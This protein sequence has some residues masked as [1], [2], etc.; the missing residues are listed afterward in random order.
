MQNERQYAG[1]DDFATYYMDMDRNGVTVLIT[2]D[3]GYLRYKHDRPTLRTMLADPI[4]SE[5][6]HQI[7]AWE[8]FVNNEAE[9]HAGS[10]SNAEQ[11]IE[12]DFGLP[13]NSM[14]ETSLW[15]QREPGDRPARPIERSRN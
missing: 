1:M 6:A 10:I 2:Y 8:Q 4:T 15:K 3:Y 14:F 13:A 11:L 9:S 7:I 12:Y 5:Q